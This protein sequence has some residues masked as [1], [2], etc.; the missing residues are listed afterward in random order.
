MKL[1]L[2]LLAASLCQQAS[3]FVSA[4]RRA[5]VAPRQNPAAPPSDAARAP[6]LEGI[7]QGTLDAGGAKLRLV[8]NVT[9]RPDGGLA[10][11]LDS[12]DQGATGIPV[13]SV[14][15][16]GAAV[17]FELKSAG[18]V[19][20]GT[21]NKEGTAIDGRWSQGPGSFPLV[22]SRVERAPAGPA[23]PQTPKG[24][25]PYEV[26]EVSYE[27]R[28]AGVRL[29]GTLTL[30][31]A[32]GPHTAVLLISGSGQQDRDETI[33]GHKPFH[34]LADYLTRRGVAVLRVDD[35]GVGGSSA[36]PDLNKAT[37]EDFAGDV[38]AGVEYLKSRKE[39]D[40]KRVGLVGH[41][42]GGMIAP[43]V[44][45]RS[46]A[47]A[48][49][50][51]LAGP[52]LAAEEGFAAQVSALARANGESEGAVAWRRRLVG[53]VFAVMK[54]EKDDAAALRRAHEERAKLLGELSADERKRYGLA[55]DEMEGIVRVMLTPWFRFFAA[56]DPRAT[57]AKVRV[58]VLAVAGERDLQVVPAKEHLAAVA[59]ALKA[60]G[61]RDYTVKELPK[62]NHL[63][64]TSET[65]SP[66]EY[67]RIEE[68]ISPVAL[69]LIGDWILRHAGA[70]P[71]R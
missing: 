7:W 41:S 51:L 19:Y 66:A 25:Y 43:M 69:E 6:G 4:G 30:P 2:I 50:V 24:P 45:S 12:P 61:N 5:N 28:A 11:T 20:E 34:V 17:R 38:L 16:T 1:L 36:G 65:G 57:L 29:A 21:M 3:S 33:L 10:A 32:K 67:G 8:I 9:K 62:L 55:D 48:F 59:Q 37:S 13:D 63:F 58:P 52:G 15:L 71:A 44:A 54:E 18:G 68:T 42:E 64:Q 46:S 53:R 39:V 14:T 60:G 26:E 27:N 56:Y 22:L 35:R 40:P 49:V 31:R 47:V 70:T 23:R